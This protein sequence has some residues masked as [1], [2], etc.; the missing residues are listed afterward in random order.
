MKLQSKIISLILVLCIITSLV[1]CG[2]S[3][4]KDVST[5]N[6]NIAKK[7]IEIS[8]KYIDMDMSY[9]DVR[10]QF[11][12]LKSRIEDGS[13]TDLLVSTYITAL[14][15]SISSNHRGSNTLDDVIESRNKLAESI[16]EKARK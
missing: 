14:S 1:G 8:D 3:K 10:D 2:N 9:D 5:G 7:V 13:T 12:D 6:Y 4:P 15:L 16:G 11:D